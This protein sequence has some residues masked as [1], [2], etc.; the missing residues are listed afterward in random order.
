MNDTIILL[1]S[2][3]LTGAAGFLGSHLTSKLLDSGHYVIGI[4]D[5][6]TGSL[7][8]LEESMKQPL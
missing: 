4:D 3:V 5:L 2:N 8:N 7:N 6:S 1:I